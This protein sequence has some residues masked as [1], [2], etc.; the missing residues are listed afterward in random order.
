MPAPTAMTFFT[1]GMGARPASGEA[2]ARTFAVISTETPV[3]PSTPETAAT[4]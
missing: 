4:A 2:T 1:P 3:T